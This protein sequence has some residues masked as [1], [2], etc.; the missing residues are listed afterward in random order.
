M[1]VNFLIDKRIEQLH[2]V[3]KAGQNANSTMP[4]QL[5]LVCCGS[6]Q[7]LLCSPALPLLASVILLLCPR[8]HLVCATQMGAVG[9]FGF[10]SQCGVL[11]KG[12]STSG[13]F[14]LERESQPH[15]Q[16]LPASVMT[17]SFLFKTK[18]QLAQSVSSKCLECGKG[19]V[20][21]NVDS[22]LQPASD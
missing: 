2:S 4:R 17:L 1:S 13:G 22:G 7:P 15:S 19:K 18:T 20:F 9:P 8:H 6:W 11:C 21:S 3:N 5:Q 16:A 14:A 12:L 10:C